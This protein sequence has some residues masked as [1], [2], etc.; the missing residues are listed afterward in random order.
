MSKGSG[1]GSAA[2]SSRRG[3]A[4]GGRK[5]VWGTRSL[6][7]AMGSEI[8]SLPAEA[9][10]SRRGDK[11]G[12]AVVAPPQTAAEAVPKGHGSS[13]GAGVWS[14]SPDPDFSSSSWVPAVAGPWS[15]T[16]HS[17]MATADARSAGAW[18]RTEIRPSPACRRKPAIRMAAPS[19]PRS[20]LLRCTDG[21]VYAVTWSGR[22]IAGPSGHGIPPIPII[23]TRFLAEVEGGAGGPSRTSQI[24]PA[25]SDDPRLRDDQVHGHV[26]VV[27]RE[28]LRELEFECDGDAEG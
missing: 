17:A 14:W 20:P 25:G 5:G 6:W 2:N 4:R 22:V 28:V 23:I 26:A 24:P 16:P 18:Q 10:R 8:R 12:G 11:G 7:A 1:W 9:T 27:H 13:S 3:Q 19:L 15:W 21:S